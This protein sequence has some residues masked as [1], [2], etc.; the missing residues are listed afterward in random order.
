MKEWGRRHP[1][2]AAVATGIILFVVL[3]AF[4]IYLLGQDEGSAVARA[5][6]SAIFL[7][8]C[9]GAIQSY[10][11]HRAKGPVDNARLIL[12]FTTFVLVL[13]LT[14]P[15]YGFDTEPPHHFNVFNQEIANESGLAAL[16]LASISAAIVWFARGLYSRGRLLRRNS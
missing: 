14:A 3:A 16:A 10:R 12:T 2:L 7:A 1:W 9:S 8:V 11:N 6:V 13:L 15:Y 5:G 4:R